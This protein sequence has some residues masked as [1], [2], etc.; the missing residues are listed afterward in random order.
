MDTGQYCCIWGWSK[1]DKNEWD[2][3]RE[4]VRACLCK[5][6]YVHLRAFVCVCVPANICIERKCLALQVG[7]FWAHKTEELYDSTRRKSRLYVPSIVW[8]LSII[9]VLLQHACSSL[10]KARVRVL[11]QRTP[12]F[13]ALPICFLSLEWRVALLQVRVY[14]HILF[15]RLKTY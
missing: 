1:W 12:C 3:E 9:S 5:C 15:H 2:R 4:S 14:T 7:M 11:L 13:L 10:A 6:V 8:I